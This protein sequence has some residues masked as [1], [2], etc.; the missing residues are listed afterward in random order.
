MPNPCQ[1][2]GACCAVYRVT[3]HRDE[4][5]EALAG[6]VPTGLTEAMGSQVAGMRGTAA[7]PPRCVALRGEIGA[8]V[9]CAIYEFRPSPCREF[10]PLAAVGRGDE[11]CN[12]ARRRHGLPSLEPAT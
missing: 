1:T 3:F 4:L 11:A 12:D 9:A 7:Q 6:R 5:D 10:A 8:S 2:C